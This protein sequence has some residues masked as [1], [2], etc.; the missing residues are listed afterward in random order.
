MRQ[1]GV[2][3]A[4]TTLS[5]Y[6]LYR[7]VHSRFVVPDRL[8]P[9]LFNKQVWY[10]SHLLLALPVVLGAP[11]QFVAP[12]RQRAHSG[13]GRSARA[14]SWGV[15]RRG[16]G[17]LPRGDCRREYEGSRLSIA[18]TGLLWLF[19]TL[20]AW[21]CAVAKDFAAHRAFMIRSYA[22]ALV[23]VWLRLMYDW[24]DALFFYVTNPDLRDATREWASWVVPLL[25]VEMSLAWF[26]A[27][28]QR[29]SASP[30]PGP[31]EV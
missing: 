25:V 16:T 19:F 9:S 26:P 22:M 28:R 29:R 20:A 2:L 12:L 1:Y 17:D 18:L 10:V 5:L 15:R 21:R 6:Y 31:R 27:I 11:L 23:L 24:Q 14:T 30:S 8:G 4:V 3:V 7:A 13:I